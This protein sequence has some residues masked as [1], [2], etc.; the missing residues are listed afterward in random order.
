M[1]VRDLGDETFAVVAGDAPQLS[2]L[3]LASEGRSDGAAAA[4]DPRRGLPD[5]VDER[6]LR[7]RPHSDR[8]HRVAARWTRRYCRLW[9]KRSFSLSPL[10]IRRSLAEARPDAG[11]TLRPGQPVDVKL[12]K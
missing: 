9:L 2:H 4:V 3:V 8:I 7:C 5:G 11:S 1:I 10:Q 12:A 6:I